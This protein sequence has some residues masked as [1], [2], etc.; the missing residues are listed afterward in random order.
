MAKA[1]SIKL[2]EKATIREPKFA[3]EYIQV[4][5]FGM[6]G[7]Q[8]LKISEKQRVSTYYNYV[9]Q[10]FETK[11]IEWMKEMVTLKMIKAQ[12]QQKTGV[13][14]FPFVLGMLR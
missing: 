8:W 4:P 3:D 5:S 2:Q 12:K 9:Y 14:I 6:T 1:M 10:R 7:N 13:Q 11:V